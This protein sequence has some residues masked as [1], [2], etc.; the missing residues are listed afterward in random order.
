ML[1]FLKPLKIKV[2]AEDIRLGKSQT[3]SACPIASRLK[4]DYEP[5][6]VSVDSDKIEMVFKTGTLT[7]T[8][9]EAIKKF[10]KTFDQDKKKRP[11]RKLLF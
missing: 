2:T 8:P 11:S 7:F 10:I 6:Y 4:A 1:N 9:D 3:T 5:K